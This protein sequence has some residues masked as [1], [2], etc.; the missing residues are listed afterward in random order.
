MSEKLT[1]EEQAKQLEQALGC[2]CTYLPPRKDTASIMTAYHE[3]AERGKREGFTPILL[4]LDEWG[5]MAQMFGDLEAFRQE[6]ANIPIED[7][8]AMLRRFEADAREGWCEDLSQE[9][10]T[11]HLNEVMGG[12]MSKGQKITEFLSLTD[13]R[14]Q[15][16]PAVLAELPVRAPWEVF[17][18]LPFGGWNEC[19]SPEEQRAAAKYW[20][21]QYGAVPAVMSA[22]VLEY[23]LPAPVPQEKAMEVALEQYF[24]CADIVEQGV[25]TI[26]TLADGLAK[27]NYWYFWWD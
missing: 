25:G 9:E 18:Y 19:P 13:Y 26:G 11:E 21:E 7:G 14:G 20:F 24:F 8:K 15:V 3:A 23:A 6:M 4:V 2:P 17:A 22:D 5:N 12:D 16:Q 27:S 1:F 10:L